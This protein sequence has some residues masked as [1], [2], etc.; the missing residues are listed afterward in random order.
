MD[1]NSVTAFRSVIRSMNWYNSRSRSYGTT[2]YEN[3]ASQHETEITAIKTKIQGFSFATLTKSIELYFT[4]IKA[5]GGITE[6]NDLTFI[7]KFDDIALIA[8]SET[9]GKIQIEI[10]DTP[11]ISAAVTE[12]LAK[13]NIKTPV[14]IENLT[15][16]ED[17]LLDWFDSFDRTAQSCGWTEGIKGAKIAN[18]L[19]ETALQVWENMQTTD[20]TSY[21]KIKKEIIKQLANEDSL[22]EEFHSKA[23]KESEGIISY[24]YTLI[25]LANRGYPDM[26]KVEKEKMI[27]KK[28]LK[29]VLPKYRQAFAIA[30]PTTLEMAKDMAKK[31]ESATKEEVNNKIL[32]TDSNNPG[33]KTGSNNFRE[34]R[35]NFYEKKNYYQRDQTPGK[36]NR[37]PGR[38]NSTITCLNCGEKGHIKRNCRSERKN[39]RSKSP[40]SQPSKC[41]NCGKLG[42]IAIN[43]WTKKKN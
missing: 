23:Q 13:L 36:N 40:S 25:K 14:V 37:N 27:L 5:N 6:A 9:L 15:G 1:N 18:Y 35:K 26:N 41:F 31:L 22:D 32:L 17:D 34:S 39:S 29:S 24:S 2:E 42:H 11:A 33:F 19:K 8:D 16:E 4:Y 20:K 28:F 12:S 3:W 43:C 7:K 38:N 30:T 10:F 21:D